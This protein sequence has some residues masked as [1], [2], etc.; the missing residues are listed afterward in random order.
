MPVTYDASAGRLLTLDLHVGEALS[1]DACDEAPATL[2]RYD[3]CHALSFGASLL[4]IEGDK[5]RRLSETS[6]EGRVTSA[7]ASDT[8]LFVATTSGPE[9]SYIEAD[10]G[11][12]VIDLGE[13]VLSVVDATDAERPVIGLQETAGSHCYLAVVE[14]EFAL[15]VGS[16][17]VQR[18]E[19]AE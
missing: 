17:M 1:D 6:F 4:E 13:T 11:E 7:V 15:C 14:P 19:L 5:A 8:R 16:Q 10:F 9:H 3:T 2:H 18:I 12:Q